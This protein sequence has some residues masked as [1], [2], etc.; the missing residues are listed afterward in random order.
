MGKS[1]SVIARSAPL[2]LYAAGIACAQDYPAKPVRIIVAAPGGGSDFAARIIAQAISQ[3]LGQQVV[4][5]YRGSGVLATDYTAKSPPDGYALHVTGALLWLLPLVRPT[6]YDAV[7]DF[8]PITLINQEPGILV[9][10][11][12]LPVKSVKDLIALA[13]AHPG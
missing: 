3:P 2:L 11:P 10:H 12:S 1:W 4:I 8:A 9:V 13:K 7:R 5:D 6:P